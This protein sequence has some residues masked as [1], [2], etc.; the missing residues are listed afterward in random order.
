MTSIALNKWRVLSAFLLHPA[1]SQRTPLPASS[2]AISAQVDGLAAAL[3]R[4]LQYFVP[5]DDKAQAQ[6]MNHLKDVIVEC[7]K[8]GYTVLS[9]PS[10]W[11]FVHTQGRGVGG[12]TAVVC[13]GLVK[14]THRDGTPFSSPNEVVAPTIVRV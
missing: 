6:Q 10:D 13:A 7:T 8:L 9:Q 2:P 4:F 14:V 5:G 12:R 3:N 1:R 11:R